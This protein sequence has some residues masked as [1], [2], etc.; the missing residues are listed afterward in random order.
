MKGSGK[1]KPPY[2]EIGPL[3]QLC[4]VVWKGREEAEDSLGASRKFRLSPGKSRARLEMG[5]GREPLAARAP[6]ASSRGRMHTGQHLQSHGIA[7]RGLAERDAG[8][9]SSRF[10]C[11]AQGGYGITT[12]PQIRG[13]EK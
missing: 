3:G 9:R 1:T 2:Y 6:S 5:R 8:E 11:S 13:Y 7:R 12:V 4:A 10:Q